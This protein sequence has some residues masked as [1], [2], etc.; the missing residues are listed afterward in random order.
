M[1][2]WLD[3]LRGVFRF[4]DASLPPLD[5]LAE[6]ALVLDADGAVHAVNN[7]AVKLT[8]ALRSGEMAPV[9]DRLRALARCDAGDRLEATFRDGEGEIDCDL[10]AVPLGSAR[11]LILAQYR[12]LDRNLRA[13]LVDSR[14]RFKDLVDISSDFAWETGPD[15][16]FVFVSP[17]GALGWLAQDIVGRAV[18]DFVPDDDADN[19]GPGESAVL[20]P[21]QSRRVLHD[22]EVRFRRA[23]GT[24]ATLSAAVR[25]LVDGHGAWVGA[26]G[27]CRDVTDERERDG[28]LSRAH[29]RERLFGYIVRTMR[30]EPDPTGMLAAAAGAIARALTAQGTEIHRI[31]ESGP[32]RAATFG[33]DSPVGVE[34]II[35]AAL[36]RDGAVVT[37]ENEVGALAVATRYQGAVNGAIYLW[38]RADLGSFADDERAI[39]ADAAEHLGIAMEQISAHEQ[40]QRLSA[41]DPL[42]GLLNRRSFLAELTRRYGRAARS[43]TGALVYCDLDNFKQVNDTHGHERGDAALCEVAALLRGQTRGEDLV[44]RLGGD[45][46]A[47]WLEGMHADAAEAKA[48]VLLER[49]DVLKPY[50]GGPE[51]PLGMSLGVAV[52]A[53]GAGES[54]EA[55]MGRADEAMYMVKK[56]G[57]GAVRIA[58]PPEQPARRAGEET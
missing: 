14:Q 4:A 39:V 55:L 46:F 53:H 38:R 24:V 40:L 10:T 44:A 12:A 2:R 49:A 35:A 36:A 56:R 29:V 43:G 42:T 20:T 32:V 6:P 51:C 37:G 26:R 52:A 3:T 30:D 31:G 33:S 9:F 47:L 19:A 54:L 58:P 7:A 18:A 21:F 13:A 48:M 15:G 5:G 45:E 8:H 1:A 57:K 27:I 28:A 34:G 22:A 16:H 25:P 41:T 17:R 23:D 50:S 11:L